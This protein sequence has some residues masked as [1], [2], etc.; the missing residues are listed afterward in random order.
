MNIKKLHKHKSIFE[1]KLGDMEEKIR[2]RWEKLIGFGCGYMKDWGLH[3]DDMVVVTYKHR[4][5]IGK[6]RIPIRFF[7]ME[8]EEKAKKEYD[9]YM[10][11][12]KAAETD[13]QKKEKELEEIKLYN[14]LHR[15]YA[16][17][18]AP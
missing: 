8:D 2:N 4:G 1:D 12:R 5:S 16:G 15:K 3:N 7:E 13:K 6:D 11:E 14:N 18:K 10:K 17:I 9:L